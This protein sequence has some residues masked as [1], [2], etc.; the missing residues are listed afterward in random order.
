MPPTNFSHELP[1]VERLA[2]LVVARHGAVAMQLGSPER[3][4]ELQSYTLAPV[5]L[6]GMRVS[7]AASPL[8]EAEAVA[9]R[10]LGGPARV[11]PSLHTYGRTAAHAIDR[12]EQCSIPGPAPLIYLERGVPADDGT[13]VPQRA[14]ICVYR[15]ALDR[16]PRAGASGTGAGLFWMPLAAL[17]QAIRG[18]PLEE[19]VR[20]RGVVWMPAP[21]T[22]LPDDLLMFVP[23]EYGERHLLRVAAKY[24]E[25]AVFQ[26]EGESDHGA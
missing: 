12:I 26:V 4:R 15:G 2:A 22:V 18:L 10:V 3:W 23:A 7:E 20:M 6:P 25:Q 1:P 9:S 11:L 13:V 17:R 19:L 24:G 16:D 21:G 8:R 14:E 5:E